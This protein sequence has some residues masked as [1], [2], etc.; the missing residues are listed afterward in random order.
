MIEKLCSSRTRNLTIAVK[1]L[2]YAFEIITNNQLGGFGGKFLDILSQYNNF[3]YNLVTSPDGEFG[4][5]MA[6]G[7]WTGLIGM[8]QRN[9]ADMAFSLM[10]V[11]EEKMAVVD[12]STPY[13]I[14][15]VTFFVEKQETPDHVLG[16]LKPFTFTL[17]IC[18]LVT[19]LLYPT[20]YRVLLSKKY[21]YVTILFELYGSIFK[22]MI[23]LKQQTFK[24]NMFLAV[25]WFFVLI[26][27]WSYSATLLTNLT[28]PTQ[29]LPIKN[30][31]ELSL[32][33]RNR[34][35]RCFVETGSSIPSTLTSSADEDL[36]YLGRAIEKHKWYVNFDDLANGDVS[37]ENIAVSNI[38]LKLQLLSRQLS[39]N[40]EISKDILVSWNMA[41]VL[42]KD[43]CFKENLNKIIQRMF[44]AGLFWKYQKDEWRK[45]DSLSADLSTLSESAQMI[46]LEELSDLFIFLLFGYVIAGLVLLGEL[47]YFSY[48]DVP[49]PTYLRQSNSLSGDK[50]RKGRCRFQYSIHD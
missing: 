9:E 17:W 10:T 22:Q 26:I 19:L 44:S 41:L 31:V 2:K 33:V 39:R 28:V 32:A 18:L 50:K 15:E 20:V 1:P 45:L 5:P 12:F 49:S 6:G 40:T 47:I 14:Q 37:L 3:K 11:S 8:A 38:Q 46:T 4:R 35:Y 7:N 48:L 27:S 24:A 30:F 34:G 25:W 13:T 42:S 23:H 43:F 21:S 36:K 29:D 16:F